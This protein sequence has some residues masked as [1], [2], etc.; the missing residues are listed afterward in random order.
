MTTGNWQAPKQSLRQRIRRLRSKG[1]EPTSEQKR[2]QKV[3]L[4][5][6]LAAQENLPKVQTKNVEKLR[7]IPSFYQAQRSMA[8][9][10][11]KAPDGNGFDGAGIFKRD[12][13]ELVLF[14]KSHGVA[15][16]LSEVETDTVTYIT[17][18]FYSDVGMIEKVDGSVVS[19]FDTNGENLGS[20]RPQMP[21]DPGATL[22]LDYGALDSIL[23][24]SAKLSVAIPRPYV[25]LTWSGGSMPVLVALDVAPERLPYL[26][27]EED[28]RLGRLFYDARARMMIRIARQGGLAPR[29]PG[30]VFVKESDRV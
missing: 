13:E 17:H 20:I 2:A 25:Q 7:G 27:R 30:G 8:R 10:H 12:S 16:R 19:Q 18:C 29:V 24:G 22:D 14:A 9:V 4:L 26:T 21:G 15:Y 23:S 11:A 28:A 6:R 3:E 1:A 5:A